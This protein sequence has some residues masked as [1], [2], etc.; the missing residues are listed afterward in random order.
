[1]EIFMRKILLASTALV[2]V[3]G[4]SAASADGHIT[5]S[6]GAD[7]AYTSVSDDQ[8]DN[9]T[10]GENGTSMGTTGDLAAAWS[11]TTD[12][13]LAISVDFDIDATE[14]SMSIAGDWGTFTFDQGDG[15]MGTGGGDAESVSN[16][17]FGM[18]PDY[19]GTEAI[20]GGDIAY[21]NTIGP[22]S[23]AI[24]MGDG[25]TAAAADG[26]GGEA[27]ETSYGVSYSASVNGAD[28]TL[29][30]AAASTGSATSAVGS[31]DL[32][33]SSMNLDVTVGS[34]GVSMAQNAQKADRNDDNA[35]GAGTTDLDSTNFGLTY[36]V[37]DSLTLQ[38][39]SVAAS[40]TIAGDATYKYD[41]SAYGIS[42]T[43]ASGLDLKVSYSDFTQSGG[44]AIDDV[45]G[46]GTM[47]ELS[48]S[49]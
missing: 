27:N 34:I 30:Y 24:G 11:T 15:A 38:A 36:A 14:A 16:M 41:E 17:R 28:V 6:G 25:G 7:F 26:T 39:A 42:Y 5:F 37:S 46:S 18:T 31:T 29:G 1:M 12:T 35:S 40:G 21:S 4:V 44:T 43:I 2:A 48:V 47:V 23:F 45:S 19:D 22:I 8:T 32:N 49:F 33:A 13:G 9:T 3:A 10:N 20:G